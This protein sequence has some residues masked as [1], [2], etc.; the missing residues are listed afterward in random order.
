MVIGLAS[1][2]FINNS[3]E[4][5]ISQME[6]ALQTSYGVDLMCFGEAFL[7]GFDAFDWHYANDKTVAISKDSNTMQRMEN[8][9]KQYATDLAF[10]YLEAD[11]DNLY[12][13]Y[14]VIIDG[15]LAFNYRR[16]STGWKECTIADGHYQEGTETLAFPYKGHNVTIAL[17]GDLWEYPQKFASDDLLIWPVYVNFTV[18]EWID[19]EMEYAKQAQLACNHTLMINS[20]SES[21]DCHGGC[22]YFSNGRICQK[23]DFDTEGVLL[24]KI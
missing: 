19:E 2:K 16:I 13:S 7:Q 5:N 12:S 18:D 22:F 4:F 15:K 24:V 8:L 14:V 10:G 6:K 21:P 11:G 17:C 9:S 23:L 3:V 1:Y 20:L